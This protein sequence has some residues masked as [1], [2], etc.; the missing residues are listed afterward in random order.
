MCDCFV[1]GIIIPKEKIYTELRDLIYSSSTIVSY[2]EAVFL[3]EETKTLES[4]LNGYVVNLQPKILWSG[5]IGAGKI[6]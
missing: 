3:G 2:C 5:S 6:V 4:V 1:R